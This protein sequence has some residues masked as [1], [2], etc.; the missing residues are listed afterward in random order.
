MIFRLSPR[1]HHD[2]TFLLR[3]HRSTT[4]FPWYSTLNHYIH[5]FTSFH[6]FSCVI[7]IPHDTIAS[8][9]SL[10]PHSIT[11]LSP[12]HDQCITIRIII[13]PWYIYIYIYIWLVVS[14]PLKNMKVSWD[15]DIPNRWTVI[16]AMFQTTNQ[17][18]YG[19]GLQPITSLYRHY[20]L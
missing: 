4:I 10:H 6:N 3:P 9:C 13:S 7:I 5:W 2:I 17:I 16:K 11:I 1:Y 12:L 19:G 14:T 18:W 15:D 20:H 8:I